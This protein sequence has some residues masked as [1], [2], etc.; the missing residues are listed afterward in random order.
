MP[1]H[2]LL[3]PGVGLKPPELKALRRALHALRL[4]HKSGRRFEQSLQ[5]CADP[6]LIEAVMVVQPPDLKPSRGV[7]FAS[8][9]ANLKARLRVCYLFVC[10]F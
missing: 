5:G 3:G 6:E 4:A 10:L 9:H 8:A 7:V 2:V 1:D